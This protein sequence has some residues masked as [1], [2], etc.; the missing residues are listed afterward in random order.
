[1]A[2]YKVQN[3]NFVISG[4]KEKILNLDI[5]KCDY[6]APELLLR[7]ENQISTVIETEHGQR[8]LSAWLQEEGTD[9]EIRQDIFTE[10]EIGMEAKDQ[11]VLRPNIETINS[12]P[13]ELIDRENMLKREYNKT[14]ELEPNKT[15]V[16]DIESTDSFNAGCYK[17]GFE[18]D[19]AVII[20]P[21]YDIQDLALRSSVVKQSVNDVESTVDVYAADLR[22]DDILFCQNESFA[23][24]VVSKGTY[25]PYANS[26]NLKEQ[27]KK[28]AK[29]VSSYSYQYQYS[30]TGTNTFIYTPVAELSDSAGQPYS[31]YQSFYENNSRSRLSA[32]A[33]SVIHEPKYNLSSIAYNYMLEVPVDMANYNNYD[34]GEIKAD[35][36]I[37]K[38]AFSSQYSMQMASRKKL[39]AARDYCGIGSCGGKVFLKYLDNVN[40][41][42]TDVQDDG[43]MKYFDMLSGVQPEFGD[44]QKVEIID[45]IDRFESNCKHKSNLFSI[46]I[47]D[48]SINSLPDPTVVGQLKQDIKNNIRRLVDMLAPANTQLFDVY[49]NGD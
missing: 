37:G 10:G 13:I 34:D 20:K 47:T 30:T 46:S 3:I 44:Y 49:F 15:F 2:K 9:P 42:G 43:E 8:G 26:T 35:V 25:T 11:I 4:K 1:M 32:T 45:S 21:M 18:N 19:D 16:L 33:L 27:R 28:I 6:P 22:D 7:K 12:R 38:N 48:S 23:Y 41:A 5:I 31:S 39:D 17:H 36:F 40:W 24:G 29:K 14:I